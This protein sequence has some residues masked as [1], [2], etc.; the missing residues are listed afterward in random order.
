MMLMLMMLMLHCISLGRLLKPI[1]GT[2]LVAPNSIFTLPKE[3]VGCDLKRLE[4]RLLLSIYML[5]T[6]QIG[7]A[8]FMTLGERAEDFLD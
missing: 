5:T 8:A 6:A 4:N 1:F 3:R 7:T 2:F